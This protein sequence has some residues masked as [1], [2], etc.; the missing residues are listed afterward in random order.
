MGLSICQSIMEAHGGRLWAASGRQTG[1]A[2]QFSLPASG[3][4]AG[5]S[6]EVAQWRAQSRGNYMTG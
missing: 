2:F 4:K 3:T 1:A 6:V 5:L